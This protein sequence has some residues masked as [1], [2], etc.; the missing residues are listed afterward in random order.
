MKKYIFMIFVVI[1]CLLTFVGCAKKGDNANTIS[2]IPTYGR[3]SNGYNE[4][5]RLQAGSI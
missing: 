4:Y 3:L 2:T 1:T 5:I